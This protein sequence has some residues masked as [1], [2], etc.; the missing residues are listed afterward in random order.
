MDTNNRIVI[1]NVNVKNFQNEP[2]ISDANLLHG[3]AGTK[4]QNCPKR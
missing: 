3:L 2:I 4:N 1:N